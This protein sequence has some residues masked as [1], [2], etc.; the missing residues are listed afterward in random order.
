MVAVLLTFGSVAQAQDPA[1]GKNKVTCAADL[2]QDAESIADLV[3]L[4]G[5]PS[6]TLVGR[7]DEFKVV[8]EVFSLALANKTSGAILTVDGGNIAAAPR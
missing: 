3:S 4:G 8:D 2:R 6:K 5:F 1:F 7:E